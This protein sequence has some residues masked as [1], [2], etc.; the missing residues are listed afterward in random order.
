MNTTRQHR[1]AALAAAAFMTLAMLLGVNTLASSDAPAAQLA[2]A[3]SA[4]A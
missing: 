4:Q 2:L 1:Y 3:G